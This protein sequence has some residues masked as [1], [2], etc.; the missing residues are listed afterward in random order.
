[1]M[2]RPRKAM[3]AVLGRSV[4]CMC[5]LLSGNNE[6]GDAC[7]WCLVTPPGQLTPG[8]WRVRGR[9]AGLGDPDRESRRYLRGT[10]E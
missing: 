4:F 7:E 6:L 9:G 5:C 1:M 3:I 8:L 10:P 2:L